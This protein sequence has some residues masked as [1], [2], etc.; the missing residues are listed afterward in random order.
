M[1]QVCES[2]Y[3][4][5]FQSPCRSTTHSAQTQDHGKAVTV[6]DI[7]GMRAARQFREQATTALVSKMT[8]RFLGGKGDHGTGR[9]TSRLGSN[10]SGIFRTS[11]CQC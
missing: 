9:A 11:V 6:E 1:I 8:Q 2:T 5:V 3:E 10:L 4:V 7:D